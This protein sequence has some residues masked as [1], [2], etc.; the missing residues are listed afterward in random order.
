MPGQENLKSEESLEHISLYYHGKK[1]IK[2][3]K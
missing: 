1:D 2:N 3:R